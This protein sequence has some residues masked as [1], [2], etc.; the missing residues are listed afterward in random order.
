MARVIV[1]D[2][3]SANEGLTTIQDPI[4]ITR[5]ME[6]TGHVAVPTMVEA[7]DIAIDSTGGWSSRD[8]RII[9]YIGGVTHSIEGWDD[10][11]LFVN[12]TTLMH[13]NADLTT[14]SVVTQG[15]YGDRVSYVRILDDIYFSDSL[16]IGKVK[17]DTYA[18]LPS[19][20]YGITR[21]TVSDYVSVTRKTMPPG[22]LLEVFWNNLLSASGVEIWVSDN[23][24]YHRTHRSRGLFHRAEGYITLMKS[25]EGGVF[26]SD[27]KSIYFLKSGEKKSEKKLIPI[28]DYPAIIHAVADIAKEDSGLAEDLPNGKYFKFLTSR[29]ICIAGDNGYFKNQTSGKYPDIVARRGAGFFRNFTKEVYGNTKVIKQVVFTC[30]N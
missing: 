3:S 14:A 26:V 6:K 21:T 8:G 23:F 1:V 30:K 5:A 2:Y 9:K 19:V 17:H 10:T 13:L 27:S 22:Q 29:G 18:A 25:V 20:T 15:I 4:R 11:C 7:R 12:G 28:A 16:V 24:A